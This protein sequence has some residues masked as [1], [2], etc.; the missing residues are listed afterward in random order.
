M[1][2]IKVL[3]VCIHNSAR[4][5]MA[6][7]FLNNL[8]EEWFFAESAGIEAGTLN[9]LAVKAMQEAGVD[10]SHHKTKEAL[11]LY[12]NGRTYH[13]VVTVC[14]AK[15]S[16]RCP[17]FPGVTERISWLFDDPSS[18]VGTEEERLLLTRRI[19]DEIREK[20][21]AFIIEKKPG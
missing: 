3:F 16:E 17:V 6:E 21:I 18:A 12:R 8:G 20:I 2:K 1:D 19:R 13:Y 5:Q 9:P 14:D 4:S 7:G 11:D 15:N 10:I